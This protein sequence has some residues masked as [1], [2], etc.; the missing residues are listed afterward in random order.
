MKYFE[1]WE[2]ECKCGCGLYNIDPE[3]EELLDQVRELAGV[4]L[5]VSSGSR[6]PKHN[7]AE[8]GSPRSSHLIGLAVD[9]QV[10]DSRSR[11]LVMSVLQS[12]GIQRI[13][14]AKSFIHFD[15]D[16][17]KPNKVLWVY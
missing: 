13:G 10:R 1:R 7:K 3:L 9:V 17:N 12:L 2:L 5:I 4:P 8:N 15:I 11:Y 6:C 16:R 14:V